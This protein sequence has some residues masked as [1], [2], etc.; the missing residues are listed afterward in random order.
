M[1]MEIKVTTMDELIYTIT[2]IIAEINTTLRNNVKAEM[3]HS[4]SSSAIREQ[5]I[6]LDKTIT[7]CSHNLSS[8][9]MYLQA[10][11]K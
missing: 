4:T 8:V 1:L 7:E 2:D 5:N 9:V 6:Y 11:M 10:Q 3:A